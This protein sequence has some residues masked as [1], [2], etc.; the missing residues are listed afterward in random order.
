[1]AERALARGAL[2]RYKLNHCWGFRSAV[3]ISAT[4]RLDDRAAIS[5]DL[6]GKPAKFL[7]R[8]STWEVTVIGT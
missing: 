3:R 2:I 6:V 4:V 8:K 7:A 1:M 5:P